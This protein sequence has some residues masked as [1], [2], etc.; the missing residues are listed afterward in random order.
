MAQK[1]ARLKKEMQIL[2]D[3]PPTG[4]VCWP[5]EDKIDKINAGTLLVYK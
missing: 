3:S 5:E 2:N 1:I 4:V